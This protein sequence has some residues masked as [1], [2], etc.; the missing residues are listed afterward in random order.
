[1][2]IRLPSATLYKEEVVDGE[3][4]F[5]MK[6]VVRISTCPIL[7]EFDGKTIPRKLNETLA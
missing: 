6:F 7:M 1:M 2:D 5:L 3:E 4:A